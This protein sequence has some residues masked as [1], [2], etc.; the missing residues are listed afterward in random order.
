MT[1]RRSFIKTLGAGIA[2]TAFSN[3]LLAGNLF[4]DISVHNTFG[5]QLYTLRDDMPKDP[6]GV[7][8]QLAADGYKVVEGFEGSK[9]IFWGMSPKEFKK[10]MDG[11]GLKFVST[12]CD[13]N[14]N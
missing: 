9:G 6:K 8:K 3:R 2:I 4:T 1:H 14:K 13:I 5:I 11:L 12:H 10:Y 7:F